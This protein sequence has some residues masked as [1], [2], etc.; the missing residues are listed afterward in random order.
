MKASKV[1]LDDTAS[2]TFV[3]RRQTEYNFTVT[4]EVDISKLT[5]GSQAGLTAYAA[6][7]YHYDVE[8]RARGKKHFIAANVRIDNSD[9]S[10]VEIPVKADKLYLR[11]KGDRRGYYMM[12]S[13][14]GKDFVEL[15]QMG[16][17]P[18]STETIGGFTGVMLGLYA[19]GSEGSYADFD[20]FS[21][22]VSNQRR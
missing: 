21:Y 15:A 10:I 16:Y 22:E 13:I 20:S 1:N 2:P 6:A 14:D 11:I 3:A 17:R 9:N 8:V 4:A 12:Y 19:Q 7:H 18:L 5:D